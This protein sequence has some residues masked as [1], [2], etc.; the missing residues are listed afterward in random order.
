MECV[1]GVL[2]GEKHS[3]RDYGLF[4][5]DKID[6]G[7]PEP[8]LT[9]YDVQGADGV[10]DLTEATTGE[11]KYGNRTIT[12]P[13]A[14]RTK[15]HEAALSAL[16]QKLHGKVLDI[17]LDEDPEY[18]W[19]GRLSVVPGESTPNSMQVTIT[20]D[21][22]PYKRRRQ[23][24]NVH[25]VLD[26][27][28]EEEIELAKNEYTSPYTTNSNFLLG[29]KDLPTGDWRMIDQIRIEWPVDAKKSRFAES[30]KWYIYDA[31][32][33]SAELPMPNREDV[34]STVVYRQELETMGI[35]VS[36]IY[37]VLVSGVGQC[38]LIGTSYNAQKVIILNERELVV[39]LWDVSGTGVEV[40][41]NGV[42]RCIDAG[43]TEDPELVLREGA[44][45]VMLKAGVWDGTR[46]ID[47]TFRKGA[48]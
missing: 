11:V 14:F 3:W 32:G 13:F 19:H 43:E 2:F 36:I 12:M 30:R 26:N 16:R 46:T 37:R 8:K 42:Y 1:R 15:W 35:N 21:A 29:S 47:M 45:E 41:L 9:T 44:N 20:C 38:M 48:L 5:T 28:S 31:E 7:T 4:L 6:T 39:P 25:I 40:M 18:F 34:Y 17:V 22:E 23:Q 27:S 33:H 24:T 10:L